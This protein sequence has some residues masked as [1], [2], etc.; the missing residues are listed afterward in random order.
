MTICRYITIS[1]LALVLA[2][3]VWGAD[4]AGVRLPPGGPHISR[5]GHRSPSPRLV[6][7]T[8]TVQDSEK[9]PV[10]RKAEEAEERR[11]DS[12]TGEAKPQPEKLK[13]FHPSE[14]IEPD[15]AVD[16]PHDI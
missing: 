10:D 5:A 4:R 15:Q 11:P 1:I 12:P 6:G 16:F 9:R 8:K 3:A 14:Q 7:Q 13:P 2:Q